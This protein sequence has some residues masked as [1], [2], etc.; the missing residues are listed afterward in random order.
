MPRII[1]LDTGPLG[2]ACNPNP[3][4]GRE[5]GG[6]QAWLEAALKGRTRVIVPAI[7]DYELRRELTRHKSWGAIARLD[8]IETG[9]HPD[10]PGVIYL[11]MADAALK[12]A[13]QLWAEARNQGYATANEQSL[14]GDVILAAQVLDHMGAGTRFTIATGNVGD[15]ARYVG[16]NRARLWTDIIP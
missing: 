13:T 2:L 16:M 9:R 8:L 7:A 12:R 5:S 1:Y 10:F 6:L 4:A 11:P 3:K 15:I 14:D